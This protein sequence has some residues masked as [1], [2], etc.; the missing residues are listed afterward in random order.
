MRAIL[1]SLIAPFIL[2]LAMPGFGQSSREYEKLYEAGESSSID[3]DEVF[4]IEYLQSNKI[5][6]RGTPAITLSTIPGISEQDAG[7]IVSF[8]ENHD[9][10]TYYMIADSLNL[11]PGQ[12]ILLET[13]T[14]LEKTASSAYNHSLYTRHRTM[15]YL[16]P[17]YGFQRNRFQGS[18]LNLYQRYLYK[19]KGLDAGFL[20]D[21]DTGEEDIEDFSSGYV[22]YSGRNCQILLG[23]YNLEIGAGN[24]LWKSFGARKGSSVLGVPDKIGRTF[25]PYRSS[26]DYQ[27]FRGGAGS[28]IFDLK[29]DAQIKA[30]AWV[31]AI[32]RSARIDTAKGVA[33]STYQSGYYRTES[34]ISKKNTLK[35]IT[36]GT[37]FQYSDKNWICGAAAAY[38]NY[39]MPIVSSSSKAFPG[40]R[41]LYLTSYAKYANDEYEFLSEVSTD[42]NY[43]P[44]CK[45]SG[46]YT[47]HNIRFAGHFRYYPEK[48]RAPYGFNFGEFSYAANE[49]GFYL[50][51]YTKPFDF[52]RLS[53]Y[54]DIYKSN[55]PTYFVPEEVKGYDI[56]SESDIKISDK[57]SLVCRL[58]TETKTDSYNK[59]T[60]IFNKNRSSGRLDFR[61]DFSRTYF[62]V[63]GE[64][65]M[66]GFAGVEP[67]ESGKLA[68]IECGYRPSESLEF[69]SRFV[70]F[71]TDS[72]DSA[73]WS[74]EYMMPGVMYS[75]PLYEKGYRLY[76]AMSYSVIS[77]IDIHCRYTR[78]CKPAAEDLGSGDLKILD[79]S[80]DRIYLQMDMKF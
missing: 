47:G 20:A 30:S 3:D 26:L 61:G 17:L 42:K 10:V 72:Y 46:S 16:D 74:F 70:V 40:K 50:G 79:N 33:T 69:S 2:L 60:V 56:F 14:T 5:P 62:R 43:Q 13:C 55:G 52:W 57:Y 25:R 11:T 63:R 54:I 73:I 64:F 19:N 35:E 59:K 45:V 22:S 34:E 18:P 4:V 9:Y 29:N 49:T 76:F 7:R 68:F 28:Y 78:T 21:K 23:D 39:E 51:F 12:E 65:C 77:N 80:D 58:R 37:D 66:V 31:S 48:Y 27:F 53:N 71:D 24:I 32:D 75:P 36:G 41:G 1:F 44:A 38:F 8:L 15:L 67:T 6:L